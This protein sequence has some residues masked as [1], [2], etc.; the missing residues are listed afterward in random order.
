MHQRNSKTEDASN[1]A[2]LENPSWTR[3]FADCTVLQLEIWEFTTPKW[4]VSSTHG[5]LA[6]KKKEKEEKRKKKR[7]REIL[8]AQMNAVLS[9]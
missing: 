3:H 4:T 5:G 7:E 1:R 2:L 9:S 8:E 6:K